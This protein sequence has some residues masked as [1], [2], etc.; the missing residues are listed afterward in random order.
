VWGTEEVVE[1]GVTGILVPVRDVPALVDGIRNMLMN[2]DRA[3]EM[4]RKARER[5]L[6]HFDE[7]CFF[8]RTDYEYR[9]LLAA[10]KGETTISALKPIR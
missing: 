5:A 2:G 4:G 10:R 3:A 6:L 8:W 7:R 1:D 9:R